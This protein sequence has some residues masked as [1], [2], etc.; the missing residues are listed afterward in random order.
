MFTVYTYIYIYIVYCYKS[1][2][3]L[4]RNTTKNSEDRSDLAE[5]AIMRWS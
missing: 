3:I 5:S 2:D 1:E 4:A